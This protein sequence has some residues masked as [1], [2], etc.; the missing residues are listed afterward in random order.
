MYHDTFVA[1]LG[2][3]PCD[4][5]LSEKKRGWLLQKNTLQ[6]IHFS[7]G[8]EDRLLLA[9]ERVRNLSK[10]GRPAAGIILASGFPYHRA[11]SDW[12]TAVAMETYCLK[13]FKELEGVQGFSTPKL[14]VNRDS[15][16]HGLTAEMRWAYE[17]AKQKSAEPRIEFVTSSLVGIQAR[18]INWWKLRIPNLGFIPQDELAVI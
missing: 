11:G 12:T 6:G 14:I 16:I 4:A 17:M 7:C 13:L 15:A 2:N 9:I 3:G 5:L 18:C 1:V 8:A 10:E